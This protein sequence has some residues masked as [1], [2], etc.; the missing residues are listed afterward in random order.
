MLL[1]L[2]GTFL[3]PLI[4]AGAVVAVYIGGRDGEYESRQDLAALSEISRELTGIFRTA[5]GIADAVAVKGLAWRFAGN[6]ETYRDHV[7]LAELA[8]DIIRT[9]PFIKSI[10][11]FRDNRVIFERG[12]ALD[13]DIPAYP[14]DI[15]SAIAAGGGSWW[16]DRPRKMNYFFETDDAVMAALYRTLPSGEAVP[17]VLFAGLSVRELAAHYGSYSRGSFFLVNNN[18]IT[19]AAGSGGIPAGGAYPEDLFRRFQG[20]RG[21][22]R[23]QDGALILYVKGFRGW[24]AVNHI[25]DEQY[26][27]FRGDLYGIVLIAALL[28]ICFAAACLIVQRRYIFNPL[29]TM[30]KE[31]NRF[32]EG[33]L[34]PK[35][36][37]QSDDEIGRINREVEG[38]FHRIH[39][40]I[41]EAYITKIYNQEATL[42][43]LTS[44]I[45]PHF[46]YNTLDS[47]RWKAVENKDF[48]VGEQIEALSDLFRRILS[49][50]EN[51]VSADQ[52][53]AHLETYLYIMRFRCQDRIRC[54][55]SVEKGVETT[56]VPKLILQPLVENAITHGIDKR[57]EPGEIRVSLEKQKNLLRITVEDNGAGADPATVNRMLKD[58]EVSHNVFALKN[59]D[60]RIK[61]CYGD[62]YGLQFDS[63]PGEGTVV[64]ILIPL[65]AKK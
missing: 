31:M 14:E 12:P 13:S 59:I 58:S 64:T 51:M 7:R 53:I 37:Y 20:D 36:S 62:S 50:G 9:V 65:E 25:R 26:R 41:E 22:F 63:V 11:L 3:I 6:R 46:L 47:I 48:E 42:K 1:T 10:V 29:K 19:L 2:V 57:T 39:E 21:F 5:E 61:L 60:R 24:Y 52:E 54:T 45:N 30:L 16:T 34:E 43:M 15:A 23:A 33:N 4:L 44:Q 56:L 35:M 8:D 32:R 17:P 40:L 38:I 18:R 27:R 28:G 49:R 55:I